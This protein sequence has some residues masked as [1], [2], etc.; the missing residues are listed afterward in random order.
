LSAVL[1][2]LVALLAGRVA[3]IGILVLLARGVLT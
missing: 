1:T 2:A 3:A